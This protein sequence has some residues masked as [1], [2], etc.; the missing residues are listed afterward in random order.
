MS[1][2]AAMPTEIVVAN[3][4]VRWLHLEQYDAE[5]I[6][7]VDDDRPLAFATV[8]RAVEAARQLGGCSLARCL[9]APMRWVLLRP[10][11]D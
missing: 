3:R 10:R 6:C 9:H 4:A 2:P 7:P 5:V 11:S 1:D 8:Y